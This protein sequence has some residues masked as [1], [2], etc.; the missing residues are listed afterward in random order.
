MTA[1]PTGT[2]DEGGSVDRRWFE[3]ALRSQGFVVE[4]PDV[5]S[6]SPV[7]DVANG[8]PG[9]VA[10]VATSVS[11]ASPDERPPVPSALLARIASRGQGPAVVAPPPDAPDVGVGAADGL[12]GTAVADQA[13]AV[14]PWE[15][16]V[17]AVVAPWSG[18]PEPIVAKR[19]VAEDVAAEDVAAE[20][21]LAQH[22]AAGPVVPGPVVAVPGPGTEPLPAVSPEPVSW[23]VEA[24]TDP[25]SA[26][27]PAPA[28][29]AL[30]AS[31]Y[32]PAPPA[33]ESA[34]GAPPPAHSVSPEADEGE[35]W[36]LVGSPEPATAAA[37]PRSEAV[38]VV[39]TILTAV[40]IIVIVVGSLVLASQ[41]V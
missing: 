31:P 23:P 20:P 3:E 6:A 40:I 11:A 26:P 1:S 2:E 4:P 39:L 36:A 29:A 17:P 16:A 9:A 5:E 22:V 14:P 25:A 37:S 13:S 38:R 35:L 27:V 41:L 10:P 7:M 28:A 30:L 19:I 15:V 34:P 21:V 18:A 8:D 12:A 32:V 33:T 24:P